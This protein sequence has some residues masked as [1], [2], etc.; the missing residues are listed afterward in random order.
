MMLPWVVATAFAAAPVG[1]SG[2]SAGVDVRSE[3]DR[4]AAQQALLDGLVDAGLY[5]QA[6]QAIADLRASG[7]DTSRF[8]VVQA[9]AMH[10]TG[11]TEDALVLLDAH[12]RR[13]RRD[14]EGHAARGL[15]LSDAGRLSEAIAAL[16]RAATL[17]RDDASVQNNL[18]FA[19]LASG[20][21]EGALARFRT[22][23]QLEPGSARARNNLGLALARLGRDDEALAAFRATSDEAGA[24]Y[25]LGVACEHRGDRAT[26][27]THYRAA[28]LARA[29]HPGAAARLQ[30]LLDEGSP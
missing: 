30:S 15:M 14:A 23:L 1:V 28:L 27:I 6:L 13:H 12:L 16:T 2:R 20:D 26:A 9:R 5:T 17:A 11:L 19:L 25:N 4:A 3:T 8:V 29:D 24:R 21:A 18:G 10:A 22:A 7:E